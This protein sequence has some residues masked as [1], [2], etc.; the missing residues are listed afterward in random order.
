VRVGCV[1]GPHRSGTGS[2][3]SGR[4]GSTGIRGAGDEHAVDL[5]ERAGG[6]RRCLTD[7]YSQ[8]STTHSSPSI[9]VAR[10]DGHPALTPQLP[11]LP[12]QHDRYAFGKATTWNQPIR[13]GGPLPLDDA[14]HVC[15]VDALPLPRQ[16]GS[17]PVSRALPARRHVRS[18]PRHQPAQRR[19][20]PVRAPALPGCGS[21]RSLAGVPIRGGLPHTSR[22]LARLKQPPA[23]TPVPLL[24]RTS[25]E[26]LTRLVAAAPRQF[27]ISSQ[28]VTSSG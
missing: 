28:A 12:R 26:S 1:V 23:S 8:F 20:R 2:A 4:S 22:S 14:K 11:G 7:P 3:S 15:R 13:K 27:W 6:S 24:V 25:R 10:P 16:D 5:A 9:C 19:Y 21:H 18:R 17:R